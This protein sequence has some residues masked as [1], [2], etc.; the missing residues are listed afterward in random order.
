VSIDSDKATEDGLSNPNLY[1]QIVVGISE[2]RWEL[3]GNYLRGIFPI[4]V[5]VIVHWKPLFTLT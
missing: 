5:A 2:N 1:A 3:Q 4:F